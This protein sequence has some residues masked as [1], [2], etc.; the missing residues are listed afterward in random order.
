MCKPSKQ[1]RVP[2]N[3]TIFQGCVFSLT[4][5]TAR[6]KRDSLSTLFEN[7][8]V[9]YIEV[10]A[11]LIVRIKHILFHFRPGSTDLVGLREPPAK[12][13]SALVVHIHRR[14]LAGVSTVSRYCITDLEGYIFG[15]GDRIKVIKGSVAFLYGSR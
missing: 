14:N 9:F 13:Y 3:P 5:A 12:P 7:S 4:R 6:A 8:I 15:R 1:K 10:L 2:A 11:S